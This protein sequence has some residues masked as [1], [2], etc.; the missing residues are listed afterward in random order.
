MRFKSKRENYKTIRKTWFALLPVTVN[1][2]TRW[3]ERVTVEG[4]YWFG[5]IFGNWY[6]EPQRFVD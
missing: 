5:P 2:E 6:W 1:G 4:Y 3:L